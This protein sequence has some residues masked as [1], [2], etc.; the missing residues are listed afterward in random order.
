MIVTLV[1][2]YYYYDKKKKLIRFKVF[3]DSSTS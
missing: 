1:Y 3:Y 2:Y